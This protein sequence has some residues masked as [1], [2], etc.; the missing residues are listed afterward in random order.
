VRVAVGVAVRVAVV[1]AV[2]LGVAGCGGKKTEVTKSVYGGL[3]TKRVA[4]EEV[5]DSERGAFRTPLEVPGGTAAATQE[6]SRVVKV[7]VG[8][9][10]EVDPPARLQAGRGERM[11]ERWVMPTATVPRNGLGQSQAGDRAGGAAMR[12][13]AGAYADG[14][15]PVQVDLRVWGK[16]AEG[17]QSRF[18]LRVQ[19]GGGQ[20][21]RTIMSDGSRVTVRLRVDALEPLPEDSSAPLTPTTRRMIELEEIAR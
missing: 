8:A 7:G 16:Q 9:V 15:I 12:V 19:P 18:V 10:V 5:T 6:V 20:T 17:L 4:V 14:E 2:G 3:G 11:S 13:R 21:F 1:M